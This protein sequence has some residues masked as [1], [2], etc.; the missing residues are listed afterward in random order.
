[1]RLHDYPQH[2]WQKELSHARSCLSVLEYCSKVDK[3]AENFVEVISVFYST[4]AAQIQDSDDVSVYDTPDNFDYLF[5]VPEFSNPLLQQ[6]SQD[7]LRRV[8]CPWD[9]PSSMHD[10]TTLRAG[11]GAH[12]TLPFNNSPAKEQQSWSA[13]EMVLSGMPSGQFVGSSQPHGWDTFLNL[14]AM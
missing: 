1:M 5:S 6:T 4:L 14:K 3:V 10:E 11:L 12:V 7:L 13:V 9:V 2:T 8:S